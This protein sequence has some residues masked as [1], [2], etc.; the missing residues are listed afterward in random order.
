MQERLRK[1]DLPFERIDVRD[2]RHHRHQRGV[3]RPVG[4][5]RTSCP[6]RAVLPHVLNSGD[7]QCGSVLGPHSVLVWVRWGQDSA[8]DPTILALPAINYQFCFYSDR[9]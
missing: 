3:G 5:P 7:V 2:Q 9:V 4:P 6:G 8:P 1:E